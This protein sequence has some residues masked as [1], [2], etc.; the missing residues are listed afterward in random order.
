MLV[1]MPKARAEGYLADLFAAFLATAFVLS[2]F[3]R[4]LTGL[5]GCLEGGAG[6]AGASRGMSLLAMGEPSP[7]Q[8]SHP[9]PAEKAPLLPW[10]MSW[11]AEAALA[12]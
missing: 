2:G 7:V 12:A 1:S 5:V 6:S 9:G 8:A 11:K 3:L 10:V 4:F